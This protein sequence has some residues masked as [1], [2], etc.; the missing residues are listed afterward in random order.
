[1]HVADDDDDDDDDEQ[2][3]HDGRHAHAFVLKRLCI[4]V[5]DGIRCCV[6]CEIEGGARS[7]AC[8]CRYEITPIHLAA[9]G[10]HISTV[11]LLISKSADVNVQDT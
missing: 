10:G 9:E 6:V 2:H 3:E 1:L 5:V 8:H 11:E 7:Y 4:C